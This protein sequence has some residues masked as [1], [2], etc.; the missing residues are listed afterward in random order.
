[1]G[2]RTSSADIGFGADLLTQ[3]VITLAHRGLGAQL[4]FTAVKLLLIVAAILI[5]FF[6]VRRPA[7]SRALKVLSP[8]E[9]HCLVAGSLII[10]FCFFLGANVG[11][12]A[13][14]LLFVLP[15]LFAAA[16]GSPEKWSA[17]ACARH[18]RCLDLDVGISGRSLPPTCGP[19]G[20]RRIFDRSGDALVGPRDG[21]ARSDNMLLV[22]FAW[23]QAPYNAL[24]P[25][26]DSVL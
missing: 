12:R 1:M 22:R 2:V 24:P 23:V 6:L 9:L 19:G 4:P 15:G 20:F 7:T 25:P 18:R 17:F 10:C 21:P 11:Y 26:R 16:E 8:R 14:F 3:V 5:A 13:I